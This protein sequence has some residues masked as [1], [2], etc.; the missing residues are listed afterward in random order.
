MGH[1]GYSLCRRPNN[2]EGPHRDANNATWTDA[3]TDAF[4]QRISDR[5][6]A[7]EATSGMEGG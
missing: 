4:W 1:A 6:A 3:D 2:H 7:D 5:I